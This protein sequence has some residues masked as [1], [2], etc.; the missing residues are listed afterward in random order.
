VNT[1]WATLRKKDTEKRRLKKRENW[2]G[3][4]HDGAFAWKRGGSRKKHNTNGKEEIGDIKKINIMVRNLRGKTRHTWKSRKGQITNQKIRIR[5]Y[6]HK[7]QGTIQRLETGH[8]ATIFEKGSGGTQGAENELK[9]G[10]RTWCDN[11]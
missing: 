11:I 10:N 5:G 1:N 6:T 4:K 3:K 2:G 8:L 7:E 9:I